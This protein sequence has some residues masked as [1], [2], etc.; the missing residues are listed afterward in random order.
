[1]RGLASHDV[2]K[3]VS[4]FS[5][6][7]VNF[8]KN[9][10]GLLLRS[11]YVLVFN[12]Q[13]FPYIPLYLNPPIPQKHFSVHL[14]SWGHSKPKKM[15]VTQREGL[16]EKHN[17]WLPSTQDE[18]SCL[19]VCLSDIEW[20]LFSIASILNTI[21]PIISAESGIWCTTETC[22][23]MFL[24]SLYV[25]IAVLL[26]TAVINGK[27]SLHKHFSFKLMLWIWRTKGQGFFP[28]L[29]FFLFLC[30]YE[31]DWVMPRISKNK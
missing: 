24:L 22:F 5:W 23:A 31:M 15:K 19:C 28:F 17:I 14:N 27:V 1:M 29:Y 11:Q 6:S 7:G 10:E 16:R 2:K 26:F 20:L 13:Q 21:N 9:S 4:P 25:C 3:D 18:L 12:L 30:R 8:F